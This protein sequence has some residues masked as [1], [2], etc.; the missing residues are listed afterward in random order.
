MPRESAQGSSSFGM[1]RVL[2]VALPS[3]TAVQEAATVACAGEAAA[4]CTAGADAPSGMAGEHAARQAPVSKTKH[5]AEDGRMRRIP[6][7]SK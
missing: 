5:S 7:T 6:F 3:P 1:W 2:L 4:V